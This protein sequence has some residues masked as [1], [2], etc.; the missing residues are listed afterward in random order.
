[1]KKIYT[2]LFVAFSAATFAQAYDYTVYTPSNSN[3]QNTNIND[4]AIDGSGVLWLSTF[5]GLSSF[6]G[7]A[8]THYTPENSGIQSSTITKTV[9]DNLN[10]KWMS[11][12]NDGIIMYNGTTF[13]NYKTS[14]SQIPANMIN[15][16]AVDANNN[17]W[18]ATS[19][20][21]TKFDG[22]VWTTYNEVNGIYGNNVTSIGIDGANVYIVD[23]GTVL[24]KMTG[25]TFIPVDQGV[26]GILKVKNNDVYAHK[27]YGFA[28][29]VN[30]D[31]VASY[32]YL[33][34]G[35]CLLDCQPSGLD[36]DET[37]D[38]WI[39]NI[40]ECANGG[41]Q[42]FSDCTNYTW[43]GSN[44]INYVTAMKV[45][46][47]NLIWSYVAELGMVKMSRSNLGTDS[48]ATVDKKSFVYPNPTT[49]AFAIQNSES[50]NFNYSVYDLTGKLLLNG[51]SKYNQ[52]I[53]S[54]I[55]PSGTYFIKTVDA[56]GTTAF[57]KI[58][59]E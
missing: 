20:G 40:R 30:G 41:I 8:F 23:G 7:T 22:A 50:L 15:D 2:L 4:I 43:T 38:V 3:M 21:L 11:T 34:G 44:E 53:D 24:M 26:L 37:G 32:D 54:S 49:N 33:A 27:L 46:S 51:A 31:Q 18:F 47:S 14:N 25:T 19:S 6:N 29:Y 10:R 57:H 48:M 9:I 39:G 42:N 12:Y 55:L 59:K 13:T 5:A 16:I 17:V 52:S 35:S 56:N 1:M 58:I 45:Q 28:K 36:I